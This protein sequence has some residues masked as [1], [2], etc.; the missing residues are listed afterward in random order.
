MC[1]WWLYQYLPKLV[2]FFVFFKANLKIP[3]VCYYFGVSRWHSGKEFTCQCRNR[4][5]HR[6]NHRVRKIPWSR[7][8]QPNSIFLPG[9][10]HEQR[11][12]VG[13]SPWDHRVR[14]D[15]AAG[16]ALLLLFTSWMA[17]GKYHLIYTSCPHLLNNGVLQKV[18]TFVSGS[19]DLLIK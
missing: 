6:F 19:K 7:K 4:K 14:H 12:L 8:W 1:W 3:L 13:Y 18:F 2:G 15:W 10:L 11:S 5:R 16:M 9:K 17:S